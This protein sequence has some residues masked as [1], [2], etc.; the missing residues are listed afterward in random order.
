MRKKYTF[1]LHLLL[2]SIVLPSSGGAG[3]GLYAQNEPDFAWVKR[4]GNSNA[5]NSHITA[6]VI[7]VDAQGNSYATGVLFGQS[8]TLDGITLTP[9]I[10]IPSWDRPCGYIAKYDPQGQIVWAKSMARVN[11]GSSLFDP[12]YN[13]QKI[14]VDEEG[15]IYICG[16]YSVYDL[17]NI[18]G[19]YLTNSD[20][21][22]YIEDGDLVYPVPQG[23]FKAFLAKLD[24]NGNVLWAKKANHP[25]Y[26][27]FFAINNLLNATNE[28][29]FDSDGN[30]NMTGGFSDYI[31]FSPNDTLTVNTDHAGVYLA[32]YS[33]QGE[34]LSAKT[35]A[36]SYPV[37][38]YETELVRSDASGNL[39]RW[40]N[41]R[42]PNTHKLYRY[43][44]F[45]EPT[46][47]LTLNVSTTAG[48]PIGYSSAPKLSGFA[49]SPAGDVFIGG[50]FYKDITLEGTT[51]T[52]APVT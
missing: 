36:G 3:G 13:S 38:Q 48:N 46:D 6:P 25:L 37:S 24:S 7:A 30:I 34:V 15:N 20:E 5:A 51:Y 14:I 9:P 50:H 41:R 16:I 33:P 21:I 22:E 31:T 28:I 1:I 43:D 8:F 4:F 11:V 35:L 27:L 23:S 12:Q 29:Y 47:S 2:W 40:S 52:G 45:G 18:N 26:N 49:V 39:Y 32:R 10:T 42:N 19:H 17:S 44:A